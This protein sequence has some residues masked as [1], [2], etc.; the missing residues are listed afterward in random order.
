VDRQPEQQPDHQADPGAD[1]QQDHQP[2]GAGDREARDEVDVRHPERPLDVRVRAPQDEHARADDQ[3]GHQR[4][5]GDE[6]AQHVD[7]RQP[8][9]GGARDPAHDG[10]EG[11]R[12]EA[13]VDPVE[14]ARAPTSGGSRTR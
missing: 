13:R 12:L 10:G 3:E 14:G 8:G 4:A 7:R 6:L 2:E 9:H 1:R 5:D 11:G